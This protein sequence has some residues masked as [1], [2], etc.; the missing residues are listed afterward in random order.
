MTAVDLAIL[1]GT[2]V[3]ARPDGLVIENGGIAVA[4]ASIVALGPRAEVCVRVALEVVAKRQLRIGVE[5]GEVLDRNGLDAHGLERV[6]DLGAGAR[7][8][9]CRHERLDLVFSLLA[10]RERRKMRIRLDPEEGGE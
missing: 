10:R 1:G 4:D 8:R 3:T 7:R 5:I 6:R 2:I 9:P